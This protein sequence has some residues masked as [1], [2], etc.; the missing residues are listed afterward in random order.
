MLDLFDSH[1][2]IYMPE[3]ADDGD[4]AAGAVAT[5][6]RAMAAGVSMMMLPNVDLTTVQP[7]MRLAEAFPDNIITAAGLHPTE[8]GPDWQSVLAEIIERMPGCR[9]IGEVGMDLYWDSTRADLQAQ[10]LDAQ[11]ALAESRGLPVIIHCREALDATLEVLRDHPAARCVMHSFTGAPADVDRIRAVGDYMFGANGII[12][13]KNAHLDP[14]LR[15]I[16]LSRLMLE[17]DSP[18]LAPAPH[19]GKR[20]ESSLLPI[21]CQRAAQALDVTSEAAAQA[22]SANA[23][24]FFGLTA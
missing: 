23:R 22:T 11:L 6:Q 19:R 18:Y 16:S 15:E 20:N 4:P 5:A 3:F 10:A 1:T 2:H 7:L 9:A 14:T 21:I 8:V 24:A 13:F 17:T 12:T